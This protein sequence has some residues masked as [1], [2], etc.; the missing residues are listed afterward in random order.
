[1]RLGRKIVA[2]LLAVGLV[3]GMVVGNEPVRANPLLTSRAQV[4]GTIA[5]NTTYMSNTFA[6]SA[7]DYIRSYWALE[8]PNHQ[9][10]AGHTW[11]FNESVSQNGGYYTLE[12][13]VRI[14]GTATMITPP[15]EHP[16]LKGMQLALTGMDS[17][18]S[19]YAYSKVSQYEATLHET[20]NKPHEFTA[21]YRMVYQLYEYPT[22]GMVVTHDP[23]AV[24]AQ[25]SYQNAK[26]QLPSLNS[27][28]TGMDR[29]Q[30]QL[31]EGESALW[32]YAR[33]MQSVGSPTRSAT[34]NVDSAVYYAVHHGWDTPQY[35]AANG[36]GSDCANFVSHCLLAGGISADT[37]GNW[38]PSSSWESYGGT[39]WIR[40]GYYASNGGV[41]IYMSDR[42]LFLQHSDPI[43]VPTGSILF[44]QDSSHVGFVTY[45]DGEI[46]TFA[47]R[48]NVAKEYRDF[49]W[50]GSYAD[51]YGPHPSIVTVW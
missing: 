21:S 29:F 18:S 6:E 7:V 51:Y 3:S 45:S 24:Y 12:V 43:T 9:M 14:D 8:Y 38:Y 10:V 34:Y 44:H 4:Q 47:D 50:E 42:N 15:E 27:Y 39:N 26:S 16:Y 46:M 28:A 22:Y 49:L 19:Q 35:S 41:V 1:M 33:E 5:N 37:S 2:S 11:L 36:L 40:T 31:R 32:T 25:L 17:W 20:Y 13:S 30:Q 23:S 48:S